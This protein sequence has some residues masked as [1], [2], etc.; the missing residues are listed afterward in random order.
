MT[1]APIDHP[2]IADRIKYQHIYLTSVTKK[3]NWDCDLN[4]SFIFRYENLD[5][6]IRVLPDTE[7]TLIAKLKKMREMIG[8][9]K[10]KKKSAKRETRQNSESGTK[11]FL[12]KFSTSLG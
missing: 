10:Q 12:K 8:T 2:H 9:D 4:E 5:D 1:H 11:H 7:F 3:C 6:C